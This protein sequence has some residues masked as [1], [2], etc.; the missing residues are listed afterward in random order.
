MKRVVDPRNFLG[1]HRKSNS[2]SSAY[3]CDLA[4]G[5]RNVDFPPGSSFTFPQFFVWN[6][7]DPND[8]PTR[9]LVTFDVAHQNAIAN[10]PHYRKPANFRINLECSM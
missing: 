5:S 3:K 8:K 1:R 9:L 6:P 2:E 10:V 7:F 4:L